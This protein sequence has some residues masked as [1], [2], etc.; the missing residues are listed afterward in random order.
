MSTGEQESVGGRDEPTGAGLRREQE[1]LAFYRQY[2]IDDQLTFYRDRRQQFDRATGQALAVSA[3]LFGL[4]SA[5][6]ALAGAD[7]G[8]TALWAALAVI[9]PAVS[10][11]LAA[12]TEL[13]AFD[14]Q[15]KLY[16]DAM[17]AVHAAARPATGGTGTAA[18]AAPSAADVV[19]RV[20]AVLRQ[21]QS[22]WGQ[23]ATQEPGADRPEE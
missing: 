15:A 16:G 10:T 9:L 14:K 7:Q 22:Q 18:P 13:Y 17:R 11:A 12:Y 21:E 8:W 2:R 19:Q 6:S 1:L 5:V 23:L 4:S 20:E 3:T